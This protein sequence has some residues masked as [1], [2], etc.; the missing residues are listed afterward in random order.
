M[1]TVNEIS[2]LTGVSIRTLQYYD[3][4]GLLKPAGYTQAGYRLYDDTALE[5]LQQILL[6]RELEFSLKDIKKIIENPSFDRCKALEQQITLLTLKKEH[7]ENLIDLAR[8]IKSIGVKNMDFSAF[9]TQKIDAYAAQAKA[10]WG[11]TPEYHEYEEKA[12]DRTAEQQKSINIQM[13]NIFVEFGRIRGENPASE[14]AQSLVKTLQDFIT[15]HFYTCSDEILA[16]LGKMYAGGGEFTA[17]I[18]KAG[19]T[20]TAEFANKAIAIYCER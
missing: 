17:N 4:I 1:M 20:G 10:A 7:L 9:D 5:T 16:S 12:K 3:K 11:T 8:G 2:K 18:D 19:G 15:E 14:K 13:M 6:F